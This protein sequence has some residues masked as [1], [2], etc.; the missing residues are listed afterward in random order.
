M[1]L[2]NKECEYGDVSGRECYVEQHTIVSNVVQMVFGGHFFHM[3]LNIM[4][5]VRG[6]KVDNFHCA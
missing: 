1:H 5:L 2:C 6:I 4:K 3:L